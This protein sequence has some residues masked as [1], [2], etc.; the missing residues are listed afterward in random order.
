MGHDSG[1]L[2]A[3]FHLLL[4]RDCSYENVFH[5]HMT[6]TFHNGNG[7]ST[8]RTKLVDIVFRNVPLKSYTS[9]IG[10]D[11]QMV[12][13]FTWWKCLFNLIIVFISFS[14]S[15]RPYFATFTPF[16]A[17]PFLTHFFVLFSKVALSAHL[18]SCTRILSTNL[19]SFFF[20]QYSTTHLLF[21]VQAILLLLSLSY[22]AVGWFLL[23]PVLA[24]PPS[25]PRPFFLCYFWSGLQRLKI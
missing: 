16:S 23:F 5:D 6:P 1:Y 17:A 15:K 12:F 25:D 13:Y 7:P 18:L 8:F 9:R 4:P 21:G 19:F 24:L 20:F 22:A 10:T 11:M 2:I 3:K 14:N